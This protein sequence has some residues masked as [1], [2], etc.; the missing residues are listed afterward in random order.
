M[1]SIVAQQ[2]LPTYLLF[3]HYNIIISNYLQLTWNSFVQGK[4]VSELPAHLFAK[5]KPGAAKG[6][7]ADNA[8]QKE[9]AGSEAQIV[10]MAELIGDVRCQNFSFSFLPSLYQFFFF[11]HIQGDHCVLFVLYVL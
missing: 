5:A 8:K 9:T 4:D 2:Y 1:N 10:R 6:G 3:H 7:K 11:P